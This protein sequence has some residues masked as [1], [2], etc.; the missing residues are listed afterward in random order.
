MPT[1][2]TT[3]SNS[4]SL[5]PEGQAAALWIFIESKTPRF[6]YEDALGVISELQPRPGEDPKSLAKRLR[7][8]LQTR[9]ITLKHTHALHAASQVQGHS[10]W[11][12]NDEADAARLQLTSMETVGTEI[13]LRIVEFASWSEL[14]DELCA[15]AD[16]LLARGELPLGVMTLNVAE[17]AL[18]FTAPR[19]A[20]PGNQRQQPQSWPLGTITP[21]LDKDGWLLTAPPALEKLRRHLEET[22]KAVLDGHAVL[23]LCANSRDRSGEPMSVTMT[24]VPNSELVLQREDD[25]DDPRSGYEIARGDEVT[26][27]HQLELSMR[28][29]TSG[30]MPELDISVPEEGSGCWTVNGRRYVWVLETLKPKEYVPGRVNRYLGPGDCE[31]LLRRYQLAKRIH[32][33]S[34]KFH[35]QTKRLQYL[36]SLP[37]DYRVNLH[38]MLHR[39]NGAGLEWE[40]YCD[41]FGA[42]PSP[43]QDRF[44]V[45]FIFQFL[46]DLK[47]EDPNKVFA[48]PNLSEMARIDDDS[49]LRALIPRVESVRY[50]K[51]RDLGNELEE[52][53]LEAV[54]NFATALRMQKF[55][56]GGGLQMEK[57]LPYLLYASDAAELCASVD[58]LGLL[59]Y[60]A[61]MPHLIS[62]KGL[63]PDVPG[64]DAWPWALGNAVFLRFER[65]GDQP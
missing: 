62:T 24:D 25:E 47:V 50:G 30:V 54:D 51:P 58:A 32:G 8:A 36:G 21:L 28:N 11:H 46:Q 13:P 2:S 37:E 33:Q 44:P 52:K 34:F 31:R 4:P 39:I 49:L 42:E 55:M 60:A 43:P 7:K 56:G 1:N 3:A 40:S 18:N 19:P 10:S 15:W 20:N 12:T 35:E 16:R 14:A 65:R 48:M 17:H 57:E 59:M 9:R 27:W 23:H 22:G 61:V 29:D 5:T 38:F 6:S 26:C 53:L 63:I 45:G 41:K 64:V